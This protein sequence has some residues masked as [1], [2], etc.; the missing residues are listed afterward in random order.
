MPILPNARM[1]SVTAQPLPMM[2]TL[3]AA[4]R[5]VSGD[6]IFD[7]A[8]PAV[9]SIAYSIYY[10]DVL[11]DCATKLGYKK[12][13]ARFKDDGDLLKLSAAIVRSYTFILWSDDCH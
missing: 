13:A 8:Y 4:I 2:K 1:L 11:Y 9:D 7:S 3:R 12:L 6:V 5:A 10:R